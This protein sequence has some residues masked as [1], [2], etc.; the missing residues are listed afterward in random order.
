MEN[1][2]NVSVQGQGGLSPLPAL[3]Q[4][5]RTPLNGCFQPFFTLVFKGDLGKD[6]RVTVHSSAVPKQALR[7]CGLSFFFCRVTSVGSDR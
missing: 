7:G 2:I 6:K 3:T 1:K 5:L 4:G